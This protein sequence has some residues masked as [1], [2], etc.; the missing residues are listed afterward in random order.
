MLILQETYKSHL[1]SNIVY[2]SI[3]EP[4]IE[5]VT[6]GGDS[7]QIPMCPSGFIIAG[8]GS[9]GHSLL[10]MIFQLFTPS[11]GELSM[12]SVESLHF[13]FTNTV[14]EIKTALNCL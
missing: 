11:E 14:G 3:E 13:L 2:T 8:N 4:K 6:R 12:E 9:N 10:T 1:G 7:S 5:E